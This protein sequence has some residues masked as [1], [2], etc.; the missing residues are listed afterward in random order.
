MPEATTS[1]IRDLVARVLD[2]LPLPFTD[3]L[4]DDLLF[5]IEQTPALLSEYRQ[6]E[7]RFGQHVLHTMIG[8]WTSRLVERRGEREVSSKR[9]HLTA[10][11]SVLDQPAPPRLTAQQ[12]VQA[13][14]EEVFQ[15][16]NRHREAIPKDVR[17]HKD[18]LVRRV[19][20][21]DLAEAA[22]LWLFAEREWDTGPLL[23]SIESADSHH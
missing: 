18:E 12:L 4:I 2:T 23:Q 8:R 7:S 21:G 20:G 6:L 19:A 22:F 14:S 9:N 16:F 1:P 11:Y 10:R 3:D 15:F 13:A 17:A 5:E